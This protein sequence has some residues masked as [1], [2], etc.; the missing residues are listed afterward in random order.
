MPKSVTDQ[1]LVN[2]A[3]F[4]DANRFPVLSYVHTNKAAM[5]RSGQPLVGTGNKRCRDDEQLLLAT[6]RN[7]K[8]A[9]VFETRSV[10]TAGAAKN[11]GSPFHY[12]NQSINQS[13]NN[14][15]LLSDVRFRLPNRTFSFFSNPIPFNSNLIFIYFNFDSNFL[16]NCIKIFFLIQKTKSSF[17]KSKKF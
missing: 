9:F 12:L 11:K 13:K 15:S 4:R 7:G 2:S 16:W 6:I 14:G 3:N 17:F 1:N 8:R 10:V 5:L